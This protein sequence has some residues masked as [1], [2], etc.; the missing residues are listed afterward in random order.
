MRGRGGRR[1]SGLDGKGLRFGLRGRTSKQRLRVSAK[2]SWKR[3]VRDLPWDQEL[4]GGNGDRGRWRLGVWLEIRPGDM[5]V[6]RGA[7]ISWLG[8]G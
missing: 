2:D 3:P 4:Q 1:G 7:M 6:V 5:A 8:R